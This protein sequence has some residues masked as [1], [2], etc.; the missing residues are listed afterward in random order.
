MAASQRQVKSGLGTVKRDWSTP[1]A[2]QD[3]D[4]AEWPPSSSSQKREGAASRSKLSGHEQRLK[5]IQDALNGKKAEEDSVLVTATNAP[6]PIASASKRTGDSQPL[7]AQPLAK[8]R[9]LPNSWND[10][11]SSSSKSSSGGSSLSRTSSATTV[12]IIPSG[13]KAIVKPAAVFL[14]QEQTH[15]LKLVQAGE[16]VFYTG[17]A[18]A[19]VRNVCIFTS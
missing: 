13:S 8:R 4:A 3:A 1:S 17:S 14:S 9:Q 6:K 16:S 19:F 15:I 7:A 5:L 11:A 10:T 2:S 12:R 18:G